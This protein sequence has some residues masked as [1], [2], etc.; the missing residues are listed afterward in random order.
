MQL[1]ALASGAMVVAFLLIGA[2]GIT[3]AGGA[4]YDDTPENDQVRTNET[5]TADVGNYTAVPQPDY[6][7]RFYD[8]ETFVNSSGTTLQ[9]GTDYEWNASDGTVLF[10]GTAAVDDGEDNTADYAYVVKIR[11][12]RELQAVVGLPIRYALPVTLLIAVAVSVAGL[13]VA[14]VRTLG[15]GSGS[16]TV[17]R[18]GR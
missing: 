3:W 17:N 9:E 2:I 11:D 10:Y 8:N 13:A 7:L 14:M 12:A 16:S 5:V 4:A 18:L 6:A 15:Q 1:R